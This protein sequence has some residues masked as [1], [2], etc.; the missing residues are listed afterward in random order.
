LSY[1][2]RKK[3]LKLKRR[4]KNSKLKEVKKNRKLKRRKK[5][6]NQIIKSSLLMKD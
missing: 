1:F 5:K 2:R 4:K 3:K 6:M